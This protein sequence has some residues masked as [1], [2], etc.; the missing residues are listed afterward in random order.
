MI[1]DGIVIGLISFIIIGV[2]HPLIIYGEY[3]FGIKLWPVFLIAGII[4][5]LLSLFV[6]NTILNAVLGI[7]AFSCFWSINELFHQRKRVEKGWFPKNKKR[8]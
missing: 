1:I 8:G 6:E 3:Y 2:F 4:F 7:L 5:C